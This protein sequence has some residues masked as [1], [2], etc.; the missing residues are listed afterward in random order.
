M[1]YSGVISVWVA[2][3]LWAWEISC[4]VISA[5][6]ILF[7]WQQ[8]KRM[9]NA[10]DRKLIDSIQFYSLLLHG[11]FHVSYSYPMKLSFVSI[12]LYLLVYQNICE[13]LLNFTINC[14]ESFSSMHLLIDLWIILTFRLGKLYDE[15]SKINNIYFTSGLGDI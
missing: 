11:S 8:Y 13:S 9:A 14:R 1:C 7:L 3:I 4:N 2:T 6:Q 10:I 12:H 15:I 5:G